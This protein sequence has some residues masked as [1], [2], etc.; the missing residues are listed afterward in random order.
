MDTL[1]ARRL[2]SERIRTRIQQGAGRAT[3]NARDFAAVIVRHQRLIDFLARDDVVQAC[4]FSARRRSSSASTTLRTP[5]SISCSYYAH[6]GHRTRTGRPP[7]R[8]CSRS[9]LS[10]PGR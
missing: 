1:A 3:R 8:P 6:S 10:A 5:R 2:L 9:R 7:K 4:R